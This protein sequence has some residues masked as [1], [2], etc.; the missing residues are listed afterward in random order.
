[1]C[2]R[3]Y[4][5]GLV[6]SI[7]VYLLICINTWQIS[8]IT[9]FWYNLQELENTLK[10]V[11]IILDYKHL[12]NLCAFGIFPDFIL[13]IIN[14]YWSFRT[15]DWSSE[16][17]LCW[18]FNYYSNSVWMVFQCIWIVSFGIIAH[19]FRQLKSRCLYIHSKPFP[20][21]VKIDN[22][23]R[24]CNV[25]HRN[26]ELLRK[27]NDT[28][29]IQLLLSFILLF[30]N[31]TF[32]G[33]SLI[34]PISGMSTNYMSHFIF[35]FTLYDKLILVFI[36]NQCITQ[37]TQFYSSRLSLIILFLLICFRLLV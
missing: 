29:S 8:K 11:H 24:I 21:K 27:L 32:H 6:D 22:F 3:L 14:I 19:I 15:P 37:V 2:S 7:T 12:R 30:V 16:Y 28:Y 13:V 35:S 23:N 36:I 18:I 1:M 33:F 10:N 9:D 34:Q 26:S 25:H 5:L 20:T 4:I 17:W 31:L